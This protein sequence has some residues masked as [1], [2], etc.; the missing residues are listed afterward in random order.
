[1]KD[2][3]KG[4]PQ[5][6]TIRKVYCEVVEGAVYSD[7]CL[8]KLSKILNGNQACEACIVRE[9]ERLKYPEIKENK[10]EQKKRGKR[11]ERPGSI[12]NI[13]ENIKKSFDIKTSD[14]IKQT[15]NIHDLAGLL[16]R[17]KRTIEQWA[18]KGKIPA[19]KVGAY[20]K[21]NKKEIDHWFSEKGNRND[22]VMTMEGQNTEVVPTM[23]EVSRGE[24]IG[25][26]DKE[27]LP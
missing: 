22:V 5:K 21:F 11:K 19:H 24:D 26:P 20:W 25:L 18:Q 4:R 13:S 17:S 16:E 3:K 23:E 6:E 10:I 1:M 12:R 15:Y 9:L 7:R 2:Q 14:D 8:Y 27:E